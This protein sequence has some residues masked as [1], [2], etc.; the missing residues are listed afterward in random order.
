MVDCNQSPG[1][2]FYRSD[3]FAY[4][5]IEKLRFF[6]LVGGLWS[7]AI[8]TGFY[9]LIAWVSHTLWS[10]PGTVGLLQDWVPW[11][12][13]VLINPVVVGYYLWS[14]HAIDRV[15]QDLKT[16][17]VVE[18]EQADIERVTSTL[19][20]KKWRIFLALGSAVAFSVVVF[21][22]QPSLKKSWTGSG[23]LPNLGITAA[24]FI[25]VYMGSM[26]VLNLITNIRILHGILRRK[27]LNVNPLHPDRCGGLRP[28]SHYSLKTAYLIAIIG[29]W[30]GVI[31]YQTITQG[32]S[33]NYWFA[34]LIFLLY[35]S[36]SIAC[37]FGPLVTAHKGMEQAKEVLLHEIAQQFQA[38]Y[39][40]I[41]N[42]LTEEAE[43]LKKR[44]EKIREL[45]AVYTLTDEFPIWPFDTQTFRRYLLTAP[46]P[47]I[48]PLLG[49]LQKILSALLKHWGISLG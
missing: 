12:A 34:G 26:L 1:H 35:I 19:Y 13:A 41:R 25:V 10:K 15:I 38:D 7:I 46:T 33:Q 49:L 43:P 14:F 9:L 44:T 45:R 20:H 23:F 36:L 39:T 47:L 48:A 4:L 21:V 2:N 37:F 5:L 11:I 31:G 29:I 42:S 24:T 8:A 28:L 27:R 17:K 16:S 6:P 18:I 30:V 32:N 40:Q 3:P 22:T